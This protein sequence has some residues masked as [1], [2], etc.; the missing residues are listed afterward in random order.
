MEQLMEGRMRNVEDT[1]ARIE[2]KPDTS[3][4]DVCD[5]EKRIRYL[6]GKNGKRWESLVGQLVALVAAGFVGWFIGQVINR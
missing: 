6:E 1:L 5:D 3:L 4:K 2:T